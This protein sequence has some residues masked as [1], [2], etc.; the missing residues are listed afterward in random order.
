MNFGPVRTDVN[1]RWD[2]ASHDVSIAHY[3]LEEQPKEVSWIDFKRDSDSLQEDSV[4]G[5]LSF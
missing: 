5:V 2:L 4:V 1:A 3:L